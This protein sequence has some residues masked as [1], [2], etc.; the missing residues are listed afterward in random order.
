M[1]TIIKRGCLYQNGQPILFNTDNTPQYMNGA[2]LEIR[3]S[4]SDVNYNIEFVYIEDGARKFLLSTR[5]NLSN[6]SY[7]IL[8][9]NGWIMVIQ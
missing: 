3:N 1:S 9:M 5:N 2:T 6:I 8:N 4:I 7:D